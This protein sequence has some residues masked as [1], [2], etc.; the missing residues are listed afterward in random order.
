VARLA[1]V[2]RPLLLALIGIAAIGGCKTIF[3]GGPWT[4][5]F[6]AGKAALEQGDLPTA[7]AHLEVAL[8]LAK[9]RWA[10]R[11]SILERLALVGLRERN[12]HGAVP[13][14]REAL[15]LRESH[16]EGRDLYR[17]P[18]TSMLYAGAALAEAGLPDEGEE[19]QERYRKLVLRTGRL[20]PKLVRQFNAA[21]DLVLAIGLSRGGRPDRSL[22]YFRAALRQQPLTDNPR[23]YNGVAV[24]LEYADALEAAGHPDEAL[25]QR[26]RVAEIASGPDYLASVKAAYDDRAVRAW[27]PGVLPFRLYVADPPEA[28]PTS[29]P[30]LVELAR[31]AADDWQDRVRPGVPSFRRVEKEEEAHIAVTWQLG[32]SGPLLGY[33][34]PHVSHQGKQIVQI[35]IEVAIGTPVDPVST[36]QLAHVLRHELG[37]AIGLQGH[38]PST[39]DL[40]YPFL[41]RGAPGISERDVSTLR[42]LYPCEWERG[43]GI[44]V[45]RR[46]EADLSCRE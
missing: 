6:E 1:A 18:S 42:Q 24:V 22:L 31:G 38:S 37:H 39:A 30:S 12:P 45:L 29:A 32:P 17:M 34:Q 4:R 33:A 25:E 28:W 9:H 2:S 41:D 36:E 13:L 8:D 5:D 11:A 3:Y 10:V 16:G 23:T 46:P 15:A 40:M 14:L 43:Q 26:H 7:R 19:I 35:R 20:D 21:T 44:V 27:D